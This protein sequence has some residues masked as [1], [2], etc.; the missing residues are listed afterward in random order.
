MMSLFV[1]SHWYDIVEMH[2]GNTDDMNDTT[3]LVVGV[4]VD[5]DDLDPAWG[6]MHAILDDQGQLW[7]GMCL[8]EAASGR[9]GYW[10]RDWSI[11]KA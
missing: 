4:T 5:D 11:E 1:S 8:G 10:I 6:S 9:H 3:K 7:N 2:S